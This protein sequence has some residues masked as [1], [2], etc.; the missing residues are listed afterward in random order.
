M[1][2]PT[3]FML[4]LASAFRFGALVAVAGLVLAPVLIRDRPLRPTIHRRRPT[5]QGRSGVAP[6]DKRT[7]WL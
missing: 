7:G 4:G 3:H 5:R 2:P 1:L 6:V